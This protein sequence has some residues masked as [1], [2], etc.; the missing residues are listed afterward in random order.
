[1]LCPRFDFRLMLQPR[2]MEARQYSGFEAYAR[3]PR[4]TFPDYNGAT[5]PGSFDMIYANTTALDDL[6]N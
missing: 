4:R 6:A 2:C 5:R 3:D 1:M